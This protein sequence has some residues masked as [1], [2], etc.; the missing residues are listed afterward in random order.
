M[1]AAV[2]Q[3][4]PLPN[5]AARAHDVNN[6]FR[7]PSDSDNSN[8]VDFKVDRNFFDND[9]VFYRHSIRRQSVLNNSPLPTEAGSGDGGQTVGQQFRL[10]GEPL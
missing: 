2:L 8:Q 1:S 7:S 5:I 6:Y 4:Y 10:A 3:L 9:R